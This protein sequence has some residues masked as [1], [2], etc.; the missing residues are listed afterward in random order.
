MSRLLTVLI[1]CLLSF[2]TVIPQQP[3]PSPPPIPQIKN[4]NQKAQ[5]RDDQVSGWTSK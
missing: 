2:S 5:D 4:E 3:Q 1:L